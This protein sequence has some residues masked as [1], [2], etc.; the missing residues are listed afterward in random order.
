M[1][2]VEKSTTKTFRLQ[3]LQILCRFMGSKQARIFALCLYLPIWSL[4]L[5]HTD[6]CFCR[7]NN[8]A[9]MCFVKAQW[10]LYVPSG[11]NNIKNIQYSDQSLFQCLL[12]IS[13]NVPTI[14]LYSI[15]L[16]GLIAK[17]V[18]LLCGTKKI[19]K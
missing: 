11:F 6:S 1:E 19:L 13:E 7:G 2:S 15:N 5:L 16:L 18:C 4:L 8:P 9:N 14:L 17:T 3:I 10:L 12:T